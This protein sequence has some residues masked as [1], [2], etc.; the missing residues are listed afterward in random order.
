MKTE[1]DERSITNENTQP[2]QTLGLRNAFHLLTAAAVVSL[3]WVEPSLSAA[4]QTANV[5]THTGGSGKRYKTT[6]D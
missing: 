5:I 2:C 4:E 1:Q 3:A 6:V